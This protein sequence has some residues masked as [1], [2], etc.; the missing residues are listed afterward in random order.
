MTG[1]RSFHE[2]LRLAPDVERGELRFEDLGIEFSHVI[3]KVAPTYY[4]NSSDFLNRTYPTAFIKDLLADAIRRTRGEGGEGVKIIASGFGGGK[5]HALLVL[6][7]AFMLGDVSRIDWIS[8]LLRERKIDPSSR[9]MAKV[10]AVDGKLLMH[11]EFPRTIWGEIGKQLGKRG[12][13]EAFDSEFKSPSESELAELLEDEAPLVILIDEVGEHLRLIMGE[14]REERE[15]RFSQVAA[16]F[17]N[18]SAALRRT[19]LLVVTLPDQSAPYDQEVFAQLGAIENI[20]GRKNV[21]EAPVKKEEVPEVIKR[22]LFSDFPR[23]IKSAAHEAATAFNNY[24]RSRASHFPAKVLEPNYLDRLVEHYPIH[25][26]LIDILYDRIS[27][28]PSFQKTRGMLALMA[29]TL[30]SIYNERPKDAQYL[31]PYHVPLNDEEVRSMLTQR[32]GREGMAVVAETDVEGKARARGREALAVA[33]S[34]FLY[35]II[36]AQDMRTA[37]PTV[38]ELTLS[39]TT[40]EITDPGVMEGYIRDLRDELWYIK[41]DGAGR[42]WLSTE[43]NV[44]KMVDEEAKAV[45]SEEAEDLL[46]DRLEKGMCRAIRRKLGFF[47]CSVWET[48]QDD[49]KFAV[50][51]LRPGVDA[52]EVLRGMRYRNTKVLLAPDGS[53]FNAAAGSA[54]YARAC[55]HLK[56]RSEFKEHANRLDELRE[57]HIGSMLASLVKAYSVV[58]YPH[59]GPDGARS[60][61]LEVRPEGKEADWDRVADELRRE[62]ERNGKLVDRITSDYLRDA[63]LRGRLGA[64]HELSLQDLLNDVRMDAD[65]P[66]INDAS[67]LEEPLRELVEE[68]KVVLL[69]VGGAYV[70][71]RGVVGEEGM[72]VLNRAEALSS[73]SEEL[74]KKLGEF[75]SK[76]TLISQGISLDNISRILEVG[77]EVVGDLRAYLETLAGLVAAADSARGQRTVEVAR[78]GP[79]QASALPSEKMVSSPADFTPGVLVSMRLEGRDFVNLISALSQLSALLG[80]AGGSTEVSARFECGKGAVKIRVDA[81]ANAGAVE[82][83]DKVLRDLKGAVEAL[84]K[85]GDCTVSATVEVRD[86]NK[87]VDPA[88][89]DR[90]RR[91][92]DA[93]KDAVKFELRVRQDGRR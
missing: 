63:Y 23:D 74:R 85:S 69:T 47:D 4:L 59:P 17:R 88:G 89:A 86:L 68:G 33:R 27:T 29:R 46:R 2:V 26:E 20:L 71:G 87:P 30:K 21:E 56:G 79:G 15:R 37:A 12:L 92:M 73:S 44:N 24:Y 49:G 42:Y 75:R 58:Y 66:F 55:E 11:G 72:R 38:Q 5:T 65:L 14:E 83:A 36:G 8:G 32:I 67:I 78:E 40:P 61:E 76:Y 43:P 48:P 10:V 91:S 54:R 93:L 22:R 7:H 50:H 60:V 45:G 84:R 77:E 70:V 35:S 62:L 13:V 34:L 39:S 18:L 82:D 80:L 1:L 25:P 16:F 31:M 6:Y 19:D 51:A 64:R 52:G 57:R 81:S 90:A 3:R 53:Q 28:I 41:D 9:L